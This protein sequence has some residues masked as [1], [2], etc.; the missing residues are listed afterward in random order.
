MEKRHVIESNL[1]LLEVKSPVGKSL[2][3][4]LILSQQDKATLSDVNRRSGRFLD[5]E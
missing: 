1:E 5:T 4:A 3:I 2:D